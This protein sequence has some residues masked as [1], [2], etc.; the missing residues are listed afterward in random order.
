MLDALRPSK[1]VALP[2]LCMDTMI[3]LT[4]EQLKV[5]FQQNDIMIDKMMGW[6]EYLE[7][8]IPVSDAVHKKNR[9]Q[10]F[11]ELRDISFECFVNIKKAI[12]DR[13]R[14]G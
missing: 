9:S 14:P 5:I 3:D 6:T 12:G 8:D 4:D 7:S 1:K 2:Y 13:S 11:N 10:Y